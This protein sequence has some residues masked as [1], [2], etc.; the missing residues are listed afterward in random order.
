MEKILTIEYDQQGEAVEMHINKEGAEILRGI[1][2]ILLEN[3]S[4]SDHHFMSPDWGGDE[5]SSE[6]QNLSDDIKLIHHLKILFYNE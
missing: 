6:K 2:N 4:F 1:L 3:D 5:L